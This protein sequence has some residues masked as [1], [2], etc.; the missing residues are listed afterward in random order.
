V[1]D[2]ML[3]WWSR[4]IG[5]PPFFTEPIRLV[6]ED[7]RVTEIEGGE[8]ATRLRGFLERMSHLEGDC[9]YDFNC[10]HGGVHPHAEVGPEVCPNVNYRRLIEHAH[11]S[12]IHAHIGS[13]PQRRRNPY[14]LHITGDTRTATLRVGDV[15]VYQAG[16]LSV[17]DDP[18]VVAVAKKHP[19]RPGLELWGQ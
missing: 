7:G 12:N 19:E 4:F 10:L 3:S 16:R 2:R 14:W 15:V 18:D 1:F 6:I 5:V 17:L 9:V 13:E 8:E 11:T